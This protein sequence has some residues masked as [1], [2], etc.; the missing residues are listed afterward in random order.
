M[1][2]PYIRIRRDVMERN[3]KHMA[4]TASELGVK[5]RPHVKTHKSPEIARLQ[6]KAGASGITVAKLGEAEVM[7]EHGI[8]DIF[9][10]YPMAVP[11][12]MDRA[13]RLSRSIH[14]S[15][16]IDSL[17]TAA[18]LS[19]RAEEAGVLMTVR[20]EIDTGLKRTGVAIAEAGR[21][22]YAIS[23]LPG[24][25][26]NGIFTYRG[27]FYQG[28][29]ALEYG[30]AGQEE[31]HLMASLAYE[32]RSQGIAIE[33][34]SAG[35]TPTASSAGAVRG[36]TEIRPGTYVFNDSMQLRLGVCSREDCAAEVVVSVIHAAQ[37]GRVVVDGGSKALAT[38]VQPGQPPLLLKGFGTVIGYPDAVL[39]R[40]N[41]EHGIIRMNP[42]HTLKPGDTLHII[43]NHICSTINLYDEVYVTGEGDV[44][45]W[46]VRA[47]GRLQ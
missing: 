44:Q 18:E 35:S 23:R 36:V 17:E 41:E 9:M 25:S 16:G 27:S 12:K 19:R 14:L 42:S 7:A 2:T 22:A 37:D 40:M 46:P 33:H 39:E 38:D 5:L 15:L 47:R 11:G 20:L 31:G 21:L 34:V 13:I 26:L 24:L 30:A 8:T 6:L 32:L 4:E 45:C 28:K 29:A 43:P 3:I 10:A 1:D